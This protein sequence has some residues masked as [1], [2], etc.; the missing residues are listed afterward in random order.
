MSI[1]TVSTPKK[2]FE[3]VKQRMLG[4]IGGKIDSIDM[5][6]G[7]FYI[8]NDMLTMSHMSGNT[9]YRYDF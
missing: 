7:K 1:Y 8:T 2:I 9:E 3:K 4:Q 6:I 5:N